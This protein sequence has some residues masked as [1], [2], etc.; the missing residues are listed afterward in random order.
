MLQLFQASHGR[1]LNIE[2]PMGVVLGKVGNAPHHATSVFHSFRKQQTDL[3]ISYGELVVPT[4]SR[5]LVHVLCDGSK[6]RSPMLLFGPGER[7]V[8]KATAPRTIPTST[9]EG[10]VVEISDLGAIHV[11]AF[12]RGIGRPGIAIIHALA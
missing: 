10:K 3:L 4:E 12:P 2:I 8:A 7:A 11:G 1:F 5:N 6:I 9:G